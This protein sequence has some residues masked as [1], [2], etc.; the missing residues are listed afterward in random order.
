M[1]LEAGCVMVWVINPHRETVEVYRS[2]EDI[3]VLCGDDVID[4]GDVIEGFQCRV[5]DLFV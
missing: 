4:G 3:T 5:H 2:P 1:K